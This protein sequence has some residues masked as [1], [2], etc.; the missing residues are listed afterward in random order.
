[1]FS[2]LWSVPNHKVRFS[3]AELIG[4]GGFH[5]QSLPVEMALIRHG[6]IV[7]FTGQYLPALGLFLA[8][9]PPEIKAKAAGRRGL[10]QTSG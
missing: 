10:T 4:H 2:L 1:V 5:V 7:G 8:P 3:F 6:W 9:Q